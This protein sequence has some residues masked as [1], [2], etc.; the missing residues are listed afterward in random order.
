MKKTIRTDV[1]GKGNQNRSD[2]S[3][4]GQ[5]LVEAAVFVP[6]LVLLLAAAVDFGRVFDA[7]IVLTNAARE[8]ARFGSV[9]PTLPVDQV[10]ALVV[11]DVVGSGTN[12]TEM[13]DFG[14]R[15][16]VTVVGQESTSTKVKVTV[17]YPFNLWFGGI[18][19]I[20]QVTLTKTAEM[21]RWFTEE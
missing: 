17:S 20:S 10:Q 7:Y 1:Q 12:I 8:G 18:I 6:I 16:T 15:G 19:G 14:S 21:P 9:N 11:A 13:A 5:S 2:R 3:Q 4:H